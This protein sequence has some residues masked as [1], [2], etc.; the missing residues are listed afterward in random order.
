MLKHRLIPCLFLRNG[1]LVQS[2]GFKRYQ[3]LGNPV[4]AVDRYNQW[5]VDE[6]IYIDITPGAYSG[7]N[8][9][10]VASP[11]RNNILDI[12]RDVSKKCFMPLTFGGGVRTLKD[13]GDRLACGAD[14]VTVNTA[15]LD[16]PKFISEGAKEYGSQCIILSID[17]KRAEDGSCRVVRSGKAMTD[18]D[19]IEWAKKA[20]GLGAGEIFL[21]SVDRDG[22]GQG[23][24]L[25]LVRTVARS[26]NVP[27][28]A[29]GGVGNWDHLVEGVRQGEASAV[30]AANIFSYKE[31]SIIEAKQY[32]IKSGLNF[33]PDG[34]GEGVK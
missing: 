1:V 12:I 25:E 3:M 24:D 20:E 2:R 19:V 33:R 34:A 31:Q 27:V 8:R 4:V 23:Y 14:K 13:I 30:A 17:V 5:G 10:D 18:L 29:C 6:L 11:S 15:A 7:L 26:V 28:I 22:S 9:E 21:N 16:D 32:L